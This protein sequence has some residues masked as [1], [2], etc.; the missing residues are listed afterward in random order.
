MLSRRRRFRSPTGLPSWRWHCPRFRRTRRRRWVR[1]LRRRSGC[2]ARF[3]REGR[4]LLHGT[5]SSIDRRC[6]VRSRPRRECSVE[7][8]A[9]I[10]RL[11]GFP[12]PLPA[13]V[14]R[15]S[16]PPLESP[17]RLGANFARNI[18]KYRILRVGPPRFSAWRSGHIDHGAAADGH[19]DGPLGGHAPAASSTFNLFRATIRLPLD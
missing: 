16:G 7:L 15:P 18:G 5:V 19:I 13:G 9:P 11:T 6:S 1:V 8:S 2:D 14:I 10:G 4:H 17:I 12:T 3:G